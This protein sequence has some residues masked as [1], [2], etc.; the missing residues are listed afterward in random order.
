M[1]T[2]LKANYRQ[3][4]IRQGERFVRGLER[5]IAQY[6]LVGDSA[7]FEPQQYDWVNPLE[8]NWKTIRQEL[9]ELLESLN[10]IPNFQDISKDQYSITQDDRW[11]T[12]FFYAYGIKAEKNCQ[13]C[14]QTAQ[15][16]EQIPG[17][18]TAFFSILLPHKRIPEHRGPYKGVLRYHL[19][20]KVPH[21]AENCGIKVGG[22]VRHWQAGKSLIFDDTF[23]HQAWN[24]TEEIRVVLFL[25]VIRPMQFPISLLNQLIIQLIAWSPYV[26]SAKENFDQW[27]N[28]Q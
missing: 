14:P 6:S 23:P 22:E 4:A 7:F 17:M 15:L 2:K 10:T 28:R 18:K 20:L 19:A 11:K 26:Q 3:F 24:D 1:L 9:D 16:I 27:E 8:A 21:D 5:L 13:R 25:D 12:Y